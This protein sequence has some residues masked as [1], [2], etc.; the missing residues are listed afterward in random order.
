[1]TKAISMEIAEEVPEFCHKF[2]KQ[3][4]NEEINEDISGEI[5]EKPLDQ[6]LMENQESF[7]SHRILGRIS[8]GISEEIL[9]IILLDSLNNLGR[10]LFWHTGRNP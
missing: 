3:S 9:Q 2:L 1:M 5:Y 10:N 7:F 4:F 8:K 6:S